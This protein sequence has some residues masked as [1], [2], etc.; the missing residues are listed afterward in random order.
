MNLLHHKSFIALIIVLRG[1]H[2]RTKGLQLISLLHQIKIYYTKP[3]QEVILTV[4][5]SLHLGTGTAQWSDVHQR[6][7]GLVKHFVLMI[8]HLF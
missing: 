8:T 2:S 3:F 4:E 1:L 6:F 7:G 5:S